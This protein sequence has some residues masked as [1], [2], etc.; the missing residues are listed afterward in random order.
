MAPV[1]EMLRLS[2]PVSGSYS[3]LSAGTLGATIFVGDPNLLSE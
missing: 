1:G 3:L 2:C